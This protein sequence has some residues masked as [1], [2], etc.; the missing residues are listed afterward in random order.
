MFCRKEERDYVKALVLCD[1]LEPQRVTP[2]C[3]KYSCGIEV[4][5]FCHP[6]YLIENP[7]GVDLHLE[8]LKDI[9]L[10]GLHGPFHDLCPGSTDKLLREV[11]N[12]RYQS[13]CETALKIKASHII[14]HHGY[15]PKTSSYSGWLKRIV[16]FWQCFLVGKSENINFYLENVLEFD[17]SLLCEVIDM[18]N[19]P[20]VKVCLDIGHAHCNSKVTVLDWIE[21]LNGRIGYVHLH[22][23]HGEVDEHLGLADG[24]IPMID[25]LEALETYS[26]DSIWAI[27]TSLPT[28]E[29]SLFWLKEKGFF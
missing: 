9:N 12:F 11:V 14:L 3:R 20:R 15:V 19:S 5:S 6:N 8:E 27:E 24:S 4:Q 25:V 16:E 22:N 17:S 1:D 23:N 21:Q 7:D 29:E 28:K 18:I 13:A 2:L 26:R 10:I